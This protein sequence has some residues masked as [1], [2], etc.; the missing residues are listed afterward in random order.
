[1]LRFPRACNFCTGET[2][3]HMFYSLYLIQKLST[4]LQDDRS[5]APRL[6]HV[7]I[8]SPGTCSFASCP[9]LYAQKYTVAVVISTFTYLSGQHATHT[10]LK[11]HTATT[12]G[13]LCCWLYTLSAT[14]FL[15]LL[16]HRSASASQQCTCHCISCSTAT[17]ATVPTLFALKS[18]FVNDG[19]YWRRN[20]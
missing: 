19:L 16:S 17:Y 11:V 14:R 13:M 3:W 7:L 12:T 18:T 8:R 9:C 2:Y 10:R 6:G 20:I 15:C 4:R 5:V 1:M